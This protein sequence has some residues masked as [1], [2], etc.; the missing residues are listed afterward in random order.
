MGR[1]ETNHSLN[2][3]IGS[4]IRLLRETLGMSRKE[5]SE[6]VD[7]S[8]YFLVMIET[9]RKGASIAT[10]SRFSDVLYTTLDFLV[11]GKTD[12]TDATEISS[13]LMNMEPPLIIEAE[14][15]LR[16]YMNAM[17]ISDVYYKKKYDPEVKNNNGL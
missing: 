15:I 5:L 10:L 13:M 14:R 6:R 1:K 4:R 16:A 11:K 3:L 9:G 12:Y 7:I 17:S 8:E 2:L